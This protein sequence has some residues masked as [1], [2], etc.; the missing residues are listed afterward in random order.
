[1]S[2]LTDGDGRFWDP[3]CAATH[4]YFVNKVISTPA[5]ECRLMLTLGG[6]SAARA[7]AWL[8]VRGLE[9]DLLGTPE[10]VE[11]IN[12]R[13]LEAHGLGSGYER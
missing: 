6:A 2:I 9:E 11:E 12:A 5:R 8:H 1:M 13:A 3:D 4:Q 7:R 10:G